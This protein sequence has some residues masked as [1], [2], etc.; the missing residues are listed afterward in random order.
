MLLLLL[1]GHMLQEKRNLILEHEMA[2]DSKCNQVDGHNGALGVSM[3]DLLDPLSHARATL[4]DPSFD[5][6]PLLPPLLF[7][8]S[9]L[10]TEN[11]L[12]RSGLGAL[13]TVTTRL[14]RLTVAPARHRTDYSALTYKIFQLV[15]M[16]FIIHHIPG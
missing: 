15:F 16:I 13:L 11:M 10:F 5:Q 9:L 8:T 3:F 12:E 2:L 7:T 6:S 1:L 4:V 14:P